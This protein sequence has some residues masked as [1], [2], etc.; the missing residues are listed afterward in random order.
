MVRG[1]LKRVAITQTVDQKVSIQGP[2]LDI[3]RPGAAMLP[4]QAE[5]GIGNRVRI[6]QRVGAAVGAPRVAGPADPAVPWLSAK[7]FLDTS[8]KSH[9]ARRTRPACWLRYVQPG[10]TQDV[11]AWPNASPTIGM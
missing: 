2:R 8:P 11:A 9:R 3:P 7:P 5:I 1:W 4:I 10:E 6:E